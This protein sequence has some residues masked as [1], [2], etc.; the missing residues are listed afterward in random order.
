M[1]SI[2]LGITDKLTLGNL[3]AE[4]DWGYAPEYVA[5]M[6]MMLQAD[7]PDDYVIATGKTHTVR[8]LVELAFAH[9]GLNPGDHVEIDPRHLRPAEIHRLVGNSAKAREKLG[10]EPKTTFEELV[11]MMVDADVELLTPT[12]ERLKAAEARAG[13]ETAPAS[14]RRT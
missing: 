11:P 4:R 6:W 5:A 14:A 12:A 7:D 2:K 3:D 8:D 9:A 13:R 1:A 10:W